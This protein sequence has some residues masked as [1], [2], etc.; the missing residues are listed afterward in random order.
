VRLRIVQAIFGGTHPRMEEFRHTP[1]S[2]RCNC[3]CY[4]VPWRDRQP[5]A[6][7]RGR[8]CP[9]GGTRRLRIGPRCRC[10]PQAC[11]GVPVGGREWRPR[12][13]LRVTVG[14]PA[15]RGPSIACR[16]VSASRPRSCSASPHSRERGGLPRTL[17]AQRRSN[18]PSPPCGGDVR[19]GA[20]NCLAAKPSVRQASDSPFSRRDR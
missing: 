3:N 20:F 18:P 6:R 4:V 8:L 17:C 9:R 7:R 16:P 19:K 12:S 2:S 13:P 5:D 11:G 10:R 1:I 14:R 15:R